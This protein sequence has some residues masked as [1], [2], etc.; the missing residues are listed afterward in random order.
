[1][2]APRPG[3]KPPVYPAGRVRQ[4]EIILKT[5]GRRM[6]FIGGLVA[7]VVLAAVIAWAFA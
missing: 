2:V 3:P 1:M 6:V 4:G 7:V 5:P